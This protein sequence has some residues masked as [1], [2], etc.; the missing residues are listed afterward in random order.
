M[1]GQ[2]SRILL[3]KTFLGAIAKMRRKGSR[4][5]LKPTNRSLKHAMQLY[6]DV[7]GCI[8]VI[9]LP[10]VGGVTLS[11][12]KQGRWKWVED[13]DTI[14][15]EGVVWHESYTTQ[16]MGCAP[17][18][19]LLALKKSGK[20]VV[21][22]EYMGRFEARSHD[23]AR[24]RGS[25]VHDERSDAYSTKCCCGCSMCSRSP[26]NKALSKTKGQQKHK[27]LYMEEL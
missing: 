4:F 11:M 19:S 17:A 6:Q 15:G 16:G 22:V 10:E 2:I 12:K 7:K 5:G 21:E 9:R 23:M 24:K 20:E 13:K 18:P 26:R 14:D 25:N 8:G 27:R 1:I 3:A